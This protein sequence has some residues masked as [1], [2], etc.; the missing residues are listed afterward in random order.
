MA[1]VITQRCCNDA[2]C[3]SECPVDCIRPRPDDP[4]YGTT[5]MLHI[6][7]GACIDCGACVD[8]CPV[9]AIFSEDDLVASMSRYTEIN[10]A[11]FQRHPLNADLGA[12]QSAPRRLP[13]ELGTLRVAVVGSGPA[14]CYAAEGL[15]LRGDV[16]VEMFERLPAPWGLVRSG[17]A[18]D[19]P[20]TKG[21]ADMFSSAF[22]RDALQMYMNVEVG[23][24][25]SLAELRDHH[26]AVIYAVGASSD[27]HLGIPGE[28]LPGSHS[29]TEF[30]AWYN[31]HP[32]YADRNFDL[33]GE[34]VVIVGNGNVA[35]D[36][37]R[38]LTLDP[39]LLAK[40]DIA[41]HA[42]DALRGSKVREV[43]VLGRRGPAQ[44]AYS[45]PEFLALGYLPGVDVVIDAG[46]LA[47]NAA[48]RA[49][50][51]D[52]EAEPALRL[53]EELAHEYSAKP[54]K[55][56]NKRIVFRYL[57]SPTAING[58]GTVTS[59]DFVR[60]ELDEDL[61]PV[62]TDKR[63]NLVASLVLRAV[64]YKGVPV[65]DL[66]FDENRGV[67]PH[68]GGRVEGLP[69]VYATGWIKRGPR[70]VIGTNRSDS[71]ETV[72]NLLEDFSAGLLSAPKADRAALIALLTRRRPE[73]VDK[74]PVEGHRCRGKGSGQVVRASAG[75][76]HR[77]GRL[78][79]R[80]RGC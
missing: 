53:K 19:H 25:I 51:G 54:A 73:L 80:R 61:N 11:Y 47:S 34:R 64:G 67:I 21:V 8:A 23:Q 5:E 14:A 29:A 18:P 57:A 40:T 9:G 77:P 33:S 17:V 59:V 10:R 79:H 74:T 76:T 20:E 71:E 35:L 3:V 69:G 60:N 45:T 50:R 41:D 56:G 26:H 6:D 48:G 15:L 43:V 13:K 27:R 30:V 32:D 22:Q 7:A 46:E 2:S 65:A 63:E 44:A 4:Q 39:D 24:H 31:G 38:V 70:G 49:V 12:P 68:V 37:A 36:V 58:D 16:E 55:D 62:A 75:Q 72:A 28:D 66:P 78:H 42:L 1:Y 52:P